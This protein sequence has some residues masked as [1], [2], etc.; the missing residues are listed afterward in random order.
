M[1]AVS[2]KTGTVKVGANAQTQVTKWSFEPSTPVHKWASNTTSGHKTGVAGPRDAK[3]TI[4]TKVDTNVIWAAGESVTLILV[5]ASSG[6]TI[7]VPAIVATAP[8]NVDIDNGEPISATYTFEAVG[9]WTGA[10]IFASV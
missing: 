7:T 1:A 2:G 10:G 4:E 5:G 3:G 9:A 8:V 6:D